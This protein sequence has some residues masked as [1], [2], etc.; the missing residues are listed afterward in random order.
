M[1]VIMKILNIL[2]LCVIFL[3]LSL[4]GCNDNNDIYYVKYDISSVS[5]NITARI[6]TDNGTQ[7]IKFSTLYSEIF[8]PV[9][10][11]FLAS[12][13]TWPSTSSIITASIYVSR[14]TEPFALKATSTGTHV[15]SNQ[16]TIN[17]TVK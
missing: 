7:E 4:V 5:T 9:S 17:Y 2:A 6:A 10:A 14:S 13:N 11:G 12:I 15:G 8:G 1:G 16:L 3:C